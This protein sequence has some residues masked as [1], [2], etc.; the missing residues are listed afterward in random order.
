M[1]IE[2]HNKRCNIEVSKPKETQNSGN[3]RAD[4]KRVLFSKN[5][6]EKLQKFGGLRSGFRVVPFGDDGN[7][8]SDGTVIKVSEVCE[9]PQDVEDFSLIR[10]QLIQIENQQSN[11]LDL[12]QVYYCALI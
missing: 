4:V 6:D 1:C 3:L 9:S 12:L 7:L 11:L 2:D 8:D 10:E 5:S